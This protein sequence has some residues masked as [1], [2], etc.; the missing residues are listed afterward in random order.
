M[1]KRIYGEE[2]QEGNWLVQVYVEECPLNRCVC[3]FVC[4]LYS[5]VIMCHCPMEAGAT[6]AESRL[7]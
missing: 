5:Q 6:R 2:S 4:V 1:F 3:V 7:A